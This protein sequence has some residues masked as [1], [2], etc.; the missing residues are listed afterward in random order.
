M[1]HG[2]SRCSRMV[3][4]LAGGVLAALVLLIG[5]GN[6]VPAL[7]APPA[8]ADFHGLW[9]LRF[10]GDGRHYRMYLNQDAK[11]IV[12]GAFGGG[13]I[14]GKV[15][16]A[17]LAGAWA[18]DGRQGSVEFIMRD[19]GYFFGVLEG[20]ASAGEWDG[21]RPPPDL[22]DTATAPRVT[23]G[24]SVYR[25]PQVTAPNGESVLLDWCVDSARTVCGQ[26]VAD[27]FCAANEGTKA[28][29]FSSFRNAWRFKPTLWIRTRTLCNSQDCAGFAEIS[30]QASSTAGGTSAPPAPPPTTSGGS[31]GPPG[32]TAVVTIGDPNLTKLNVRASPGGTVLGTVPEGQSVSI[33]GEC[34][35]TPA[36]GLAKTLG[37]PSGGSGKS[38]GQTPM[39]G[40]G[41]TP[42]WC[43]IDAPMNGCV[44]AQF[45]ALGQTG[46]AAGLAKQQTLGK[47][48]SGAGTGFAGSWDA[49]A[50]GVAY[51]IALSQKGSSVNGRYKGADGSAGSIS[52]RMKGGVLRFS[53]KQNDGQ[54]GSGQF[55]LSADGQSFTGSY[56]LANKPNM[57]GTWNGTRR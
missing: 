5:S 38:P 55:T 24:A 10:S 25:Y 13:T 9:Y 37:K 28:V 31:C 16:G 57:G 47:P 56:R 50:D 51:R 4:R 14:G 23:G 11:G 32:G 40:T 26:D 36:A 27:Q 15:V 41:G 52:G 1:T 8:T 30:C 19:D 20:L 17:K 29:G 45:L 7:A 48:S 2:V 42:G 43:Q 3:S 33:V 53:W 12:S 44:S 34:G 35:G 49:E 22:T 54:R 18:M 39:P 6:V 46:D 21:S